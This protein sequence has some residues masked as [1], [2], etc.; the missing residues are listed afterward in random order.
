MKESKSIP[1]LIFQIE[2]FER[3]VILLSKK[4][5]VFT[6]STQKMVRNN[7]FNE[8]KAKQYYKPKFDLVNI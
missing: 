1:N 2:Q 6:G 4:S 7:N 5:K 8:S 3:H